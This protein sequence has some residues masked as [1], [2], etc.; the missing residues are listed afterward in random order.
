MVDGVEERPDVRVE[1]PVD[2][3]LDCYRQRIKCIVRRP[4]RSEPV[5]E[6]DEL[7]F[8]DRL[9]HHPRGLLDNFVLQ[10]R[11][12]DWSQFSIAF[13]DVNATD[14]LRM[15]AATMDSVLQVAQAF[16]Q[17][18]AICFPGDSVHASCR[19]FPEPSIG[20]LQDRHLHMAEQRGPLLLWLLL[21]SLSDPL[22]ERERIVLALS[23]GCV[24]CS[25]FSLG[26][27]PSLHRLD[28]RYPRLRRLLRYYALV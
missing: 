7:G 3:A 22:Q 10:R 17:T 4:L 11:D 5:R 24:S 28:G 19:S 14:R 23:L 13:R 26:L 16:V 2:L 8:V 20:L 27:G 25:R 21:C 12:T 15:V 6:P 18:L 9:Q 1:H